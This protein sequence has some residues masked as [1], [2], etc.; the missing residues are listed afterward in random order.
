MSSDNWPTQ[1]PP[2]LRTY[3]IW[4]AVL[5]II[6][7][8]MVFRSKEEQRDGTINIKRDDAEMTAAIARARASLPQFWKVFDRRE[9][10]ESDFALKVGITDGNGTEHFWANEIA[11]TNGQTMGTIN[12]DADIVKKVKLGDRIVI[13]EADISDWTYMRDGKMVGNYTLRVLFKKMS[14][15]EVERY[16]QMMADP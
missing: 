5:A 4:I 9:R 6:P 3:A 16:K 12:N 2:T 15:S 8:I 14:A 11:R 1:T 10:G 7:L 13:P